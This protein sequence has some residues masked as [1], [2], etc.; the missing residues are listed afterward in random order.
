M[1][2]IE[3]IRQSSYGPDRLK[4]IYEAFDR[5]WEAVKPLLDDNPLAHEAARL[6]LA[7]TILSMA[8]GDL[9]DHGAPA[10]ASP[11][12]VSSIPPLNKNG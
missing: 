3:L 1:K 6:K 4:Q 7:N 5:A 12:D 8:K 2:A 11:S 10:T 9:V